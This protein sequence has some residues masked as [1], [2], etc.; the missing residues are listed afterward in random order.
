[1]VGAILVIWIVIFW[2]LGD[3]VAR[4]TGRSATEGVLLGLLLGPLGL[5]LVALLPRIDRGE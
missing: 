4:Q 1:M 2:A 5:I 3:Y